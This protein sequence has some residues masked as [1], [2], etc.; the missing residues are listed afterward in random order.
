VAIKL[1]L[2]VWPKKQRRKRMMIL[3]F[4]VQMR[5][6]HAIPYSLKIFS[7]VKNFDIE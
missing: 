5:Y 6:I 3:I 7:R 2:V 1:N 4:L